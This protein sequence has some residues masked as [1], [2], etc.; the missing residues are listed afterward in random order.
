[1]QWSCVV[2]VGHLLTPVRGSRLEMVPVSKYWSPADPSQRV[3]S[4]DDSSE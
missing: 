3:S 1:M 2:S 4:G